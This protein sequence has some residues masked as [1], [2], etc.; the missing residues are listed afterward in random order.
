MLT[1]PVMANA[2]LKDKLEHLQRLAPD[3][4]ATSNIGCALHLGAG[5]RA[6]DLGVTVLHPVALIA[7]QLPD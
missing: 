2:L 1:Q 3:L 6:Q 7:Q 4:L 5:L